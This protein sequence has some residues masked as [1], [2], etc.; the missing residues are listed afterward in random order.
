MPPVDWTLTSF[1]HA[2]SGFI[3]PSGPGKSSEGNTGENVSRETRHSMPPVDLTLTSFDYAIS[4][5]IGPSG[6]W[7]SKSEIQAKMFHVKHFRLPGET[8]P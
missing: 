2:I 6:K 7:N 5:F 4:G 1:G 8:R 3:G